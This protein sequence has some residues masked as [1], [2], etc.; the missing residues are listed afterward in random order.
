M[1]LRE[2]LGEG[3]C[4]VGVPSCVRNSGEGS[5]GAIEGS[6]AGRVAPELARSLGD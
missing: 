3:A 5:A 6:D 4:E 1:L 2:A